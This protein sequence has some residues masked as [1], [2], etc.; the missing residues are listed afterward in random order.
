M[1][2]LLYMKT[3]FMTNQV[4]SFAPLKDQHLVVNNIC[5]HLTSPCVHNGQDLKDIITRPNLHYSARQGL[6]G[7]GG[8]T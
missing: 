2:G 6:K 1:N 8:G 7:V 3:F 4:Q 5:K